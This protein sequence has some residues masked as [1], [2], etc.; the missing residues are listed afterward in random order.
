MVHS[1][2]SVKWQCQMAVSEMMG[3]GGWEKSEWDVHV[4]DE[5]GQII[6]VICALKDGKIYESAGEELRKVLDEYFP[7]TTGNTLELFRESWEEHRRVE[8]E[9]RATWGEQSGNL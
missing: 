8:A 2:C 7:L 6:P 3:H 1:E 4:D 5:T 9:H